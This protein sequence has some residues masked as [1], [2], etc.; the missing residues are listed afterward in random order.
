Q[1]SDVYSLGCMLFSL[2]TGGPPFQ[3]EGSGD[4]LAMHLREPPPAPSSRLPG[5]PPAIDRLVLPCL[6]KEP[7]QRFPPGTEPRAAIAAGNH[8]AAPVE[9]HAAAPS[10]PAPA[11]APVPNPA[12]APA[13]APGSPAP[14][15]APAPPDP[16]VELGKGMARMISLFVAWSRDHAGAPCPRADE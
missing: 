7:H 14:A 16:S 10:Q 5:L 11:A 12:P 3:A 13:D 2:V 9:A 8:A 4:V 6:A 1:R 15:A